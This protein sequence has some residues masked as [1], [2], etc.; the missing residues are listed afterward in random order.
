MLS[1]NLSFLMTVN[2]RCGIGNNGLGD[3]G[4]GGGEA[5]GAIG[6]SYAKER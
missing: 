6:G 4:G 2:V 3:T 5:A 1:Y